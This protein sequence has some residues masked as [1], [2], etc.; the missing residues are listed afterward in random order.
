MNYEVK[1][2][3]FFELKNIKKV[4]KFDYNLRHVETTF[5]L[6]KYVLELVLLYED[7]NEEKIEEEIELPIEFN[8]SMTEQLSADVK[9]IDIKT[10]EGNGVEI[11]FEFLIKIDN[12]NS[13]EKE[14]EKQEIKEIYQQELEDKLQL[15]DE[16]V[17][18]KKEEILLN[19]GCDENDSFLNLKTDFIRC[20]VINLDDNNLDK[21]SEKYNFSMD[22]LFNLKKSNNKLIVYDKD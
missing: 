12:I 9:D 16:E 3:K 5:D 15:R 21:L 11:C 19:I 6:E 20:K 14:E 1:E 8:T 13:T 2:K 7:I 18:V 4:L 10:I 22:Y 17:E